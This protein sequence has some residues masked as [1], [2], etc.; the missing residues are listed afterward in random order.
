MRVIALVLLLVAAAEAFVTNVGAKSRI[1]TKRDA[2]VPDGM[3]PEQYKALKEKEKKKK[4]GNFDGLSGAQFRSRSMEDYQK[5]REK[6]TL[7]P[8]MPMKF[9]LQ[10][11]NSGKIRPIDIPYMQR[12]RGK[13]DNSDLTRQGFWKTAPKGYS[14]PGVTGPVPGVKYSGNGA[15]STAI[16]PGGKA[17]GGFKLPWQK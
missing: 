1:A 17:G 8:N 14:G 7:E 5:G 15:G 2:Y 10:K 12:P 11:L 9:T 6:G 16:G 4:V 13:P 3:T